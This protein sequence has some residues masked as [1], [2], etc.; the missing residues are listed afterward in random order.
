MDISYVLEFVVL[1]DT[2]SFSAASYQLHMSQAALSKHIQSM[3]RE[4]GHPLFIRTTRNVEISEYG[5]IYLPYARQISENVRKA[6]AARIAFE[7]R[8]D[9]RTIIGVVHNPDLFMATEL[10]S[11]FRR[12]YP[13]IPI[14]IFEGSLK[15]LRREFL[16]GRL[17]IISM[18]YSTW[19]KAQ[20]HFIPAGK[21]RLT[22][23]IPKDH[24][25]AEYESIPLRHL[26]NVPLLVPEQTSFPYQYLLHFFQQEE[27]HPDIVY[28][29]NT[30]GVK[31]LLKEGMGIFIQ[32][33]A[34]A[35]T[36]M[37]ENLVI[38]RLEPDISYTFGLEYQD[39]LTKNER[40]YVNYIK[41]MLAV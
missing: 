21:S 27:I 33:E 36:Q 31:H 4:L 18:A 12:E 9:A 1:A 39:H 10:I 17:H 6:E 19:E 35:K 8:S 40:I 25:L 32:D 3:E 41:K 26:G 34:I 14:Q 23:L 5:Q 29:G 38:R 24:F 2:K 11:G 28:Q 13:G 22:A 15:E 30:T 37:D 7:K 16:M 20:N